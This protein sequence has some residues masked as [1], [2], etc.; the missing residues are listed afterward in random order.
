MVR[1]DSFVSVLPDAGVPLEQI[2]QLVGHSGTTIT[3]L[4]YGTSCGG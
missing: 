1:E 3:E 4:V 2:S